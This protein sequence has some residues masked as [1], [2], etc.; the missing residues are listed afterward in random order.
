MSTTAINVFLRLAYAKC[1]DDY[2]PKGYMLLGDAEWFESTGDAIFRF[3]VSTADG[4]KQ[5]PDYQKL[6]IY[7][8]HTG[9][10]F[11]LHGPGYSTGTIDT[12]SGAT[13]FGD[14]EQYSKAIDSTARYML[15]LVDQLI[16]KTGLSA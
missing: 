10:L 3:S 12:T 11:E 4:S 2:T 8:K 7:P 13:S 9:G 15:G 1:R 14:Y 6:P 5:E 16:A